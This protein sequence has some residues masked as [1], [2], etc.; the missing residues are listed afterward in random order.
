MKP[1]NPIPATIPADRMPAMS[2]AK[3]DYVVLIW[4][5]N[6]KDPVDP[7]KTYKWNDFDVFRVQNG[8]IAEHWDGAMKNPPSG[9]GKE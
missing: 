2:F 1:V 7:A 3:G 8:K 9:A 6:G 4:E 5:R